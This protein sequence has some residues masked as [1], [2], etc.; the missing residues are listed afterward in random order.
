LVKFK[1]E[2]KELEMKECTFQPNKDLK[3][4]NPKDVKETINN[5]YINGV[6]KIKSKNAAEVKEPE[7][8]AECTFHP[9][10]HEM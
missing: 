5:L 1:E 3:K 4:I 10:I 8:L 7:V 2:Q 9:E 6:N